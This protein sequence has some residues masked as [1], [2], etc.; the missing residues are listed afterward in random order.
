M[1][2]S[3]PH[4]SPSRLGSCVLALL[5]A[6]AT[7]A[8]AQETTSTATTAK[9][10]A[11]VTLQVRQA[12]VADV[13]RH[14][15]RLAQVPL[16]ITP[17]VEGRIDLTLDAVPARAALDVVLEAAE[18]EAG[19]V[20][21]V[22]VVSPR[23]PAPPAPEPEPDP[24]DALVEQYSTAKDD[25]RTVLEGKDLVGTPEGP[26][27]EPTLPPVSAETGT[28]RP[29]PDYDGREARPMSAGEILA[30]V[31]RALF[32]PVHLV[33]N[34]LVRV[35]I[36]WSLT[37]LEEHYVFKRIERLITFRDGKSVIYPTFFGDF[38]LRPAVGLIN[39]NNDL[40]FAGNSLSVGVGYGGDDFIHLGATNT[41]TVLSDDSGR[42][43]LFADFIIRPDQ[44]YYGE[45]PF[46]ST[47]DRYNYKIRR[48]NVGWDLRAVLADLT[49]I[50]FFQSFRDVEFNDDAINDTLALL[51]PAPGDCG[52]EDF[53]YTPRATPYAPCGYTNDGGYRLLTSGIEVKLDS[54]DPD[55]EFQAGSGVLLEAHA[56]FE[57]DPNDLARHFV[58]FG[59]EAAGFWD[60]TG[61]GHTLALRVVMDTAERTGSSDK[62]IPFTELPTLGGLETMRG[63]LPRRFIGDSAFMTEL[64]Y[65]Y[66]IWSLIDAELFASVGNTFDHNFSGFSFERLHLSSGIGLR[67]SFTRDASLQLLFAI[68]TKRFEEMENDRFE[69]DSIRFAFGYVQGF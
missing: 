14:V 22:L 40:F 64:S 57:F 58:R 10:P 49:W 68:G 48:L 16:A 13:L 46:T 26:P 34:Y 18:L 44:P 19:W 5:A 53:S 36:V 55:T 24:V 62:P 43:R 21:D 8:S 12:P 27:R 33:M 7:P 15:A 25:L 32:L 17:G 2:S 11:A 41:T 56:T 1:D 37:R 45:G 67:T 20:S 47:D 9:G 61:V 23:P 59:G 69:V 66:P 4:A 52:T 54:R 60:F 31:P 39:N 3:M 65:R 50:R 6:A 51:A 35:P 42:L 38:G 30:W 28:K 29:L 63:F